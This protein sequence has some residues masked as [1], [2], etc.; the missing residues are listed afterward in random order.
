MI[1]WKQIFQHLTLNHKSTW[2]EWQSEEKS[3]MLRSMARHLSFNPASDII[4][5]E[6]CFAIGFGKSWLTVFFKCFCF[7]WKMVVT[8]LK[9]WLNSEVHDIMVFRSWYLLNHWKWQINVRLLERCEC[10]NTNVHFRLR[11]KCSARYCEPC[12]RCLRYDHLI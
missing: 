6:K 1:R 11:H 8:T 10:H 3:A 4:W 5:S 2:Y 7:P 9:A 12:G